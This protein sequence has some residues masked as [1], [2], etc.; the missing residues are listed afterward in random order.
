MTGTVSGKYVVGW[1]GD[2]WYRATAVG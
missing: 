1:G 2:V